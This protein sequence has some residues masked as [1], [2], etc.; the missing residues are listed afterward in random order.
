M[1]I[2]IRKVIRRMRSSRG[3][4]AF[5]LAAVATAVAGAS[6]VGAAPKAV[7]P[8]A[9]EFVPSAYDMKLPAWAPPMLEPRSNPTTQAKVDLG[10]RLFYDGRLSG[11]GM[12][13]CS[14]CH[15]QDRAFSDKS[16][17]S[18]GVS[19]QQTSRQTM[20]LTNVGYANSLTWIKPQVHLLE[21]Q[22][23]GPMF[24]KEPVEM[25]LSGQ[26]ADLVY[27]LSIQPAY[28]NLFPRAFPET[29]GAISLDNITK[30]LSAFERTL[31]SFRSPYD[32]Y[33]YEGD[34]SAISDAAKRG[35]ALFFGDR[36]KCG[37]CHTAPFF[38]DAVRPGQ[39]TD[40]PTGFHN[41]GLFNIDG[42]GAYPASNPGAI[43]ITG[44][45]EH[46]GAF[47]TPS[48]R[49]VAV[50][51]P[52]MHDGSMLTLEAVIDHYAAG[53]R[54]IRSGEPSGGDGR[55]NPLKSPQITGFSITPQERADVIAFLNSLTDT[56]FLTDP[57]LGDPWK[58]DPAGR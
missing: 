31:V 9:N 37:S 52:Y 2:R 40:T 34:A 46:K 22:A 7:G 4:L 3:T 10:R 42:A 55:A 17:F 19:G 20:P 58:Q 12:R 1:S 53:G 57:R 45:P 15:R 47:K 29:R 5:V 32:R 16:P 24:G 50:T 25:G 33:K 26:E 43:A 18:W 6:A 8:R 28:Q 51:G 54:M 35:E 41:T 44:K 36:L 30:A 11:D 21:E 14:S 48:L 23:L 27:R 39:P 49:N 38:T 13:P 56:E